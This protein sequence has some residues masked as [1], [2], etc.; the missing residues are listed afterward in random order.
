MTY[1]P[2][3]FDLTG[4]TALVTGAGSANGIGFA[5]ARILGS[6]GA[7]VVI[8]AT[9]DRIH[10]RVAELSAAGLEAV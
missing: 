2:A 7:R 4:H 1:T 3:E 10:E 5:A 8:T 6:L 9:T